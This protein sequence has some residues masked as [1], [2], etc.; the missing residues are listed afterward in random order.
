MRIEGS[1]GW[2]HVGPRTDAVANVRASFPNDG[3]DDVETVYS[4]AETF[5]GGM[6]QI[7][8]PRAMKTQKVIA[9]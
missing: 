9:T 3:T 5:R 4:M 2:I 1:G 6:Q 8:F 7:I